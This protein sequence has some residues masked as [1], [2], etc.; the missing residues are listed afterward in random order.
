V[1]ALA[2]RS[3]LL[4]PDRPRLCVPRRPPSTAR[5]ARRASTTYGGGGKRGA[6]AGGEHCTVR[7]NSS[8]ARPSGCGAAGE[9][10]ADR[11][12]S[13]DA[14]NTIRCRWTATLLIYVRVSSSESSA[15]ARSAGCARL[16]G[17]GGAVS[18]PQRC[19]H[20]CDAP[21]E[22]TGPPPFLT[23]LGRPCRSSDRN[24]RGI[25]CSSRSVS[26]NVDEP[27]HVLDRRVRRDRP[28]RVAR[29]LVRP[30]STAAAQEPILE[31]LGMNDRA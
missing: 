21:S 24:V 4:G 26:R 19:G 6:A 20:A 22:R 16:A 30:Y 27:T 2:S 17:F 5:A 12:G 29:L 10:T 31:P 7:G 1:T 28:A 18:G 11:S 3:P 9:D 13:R 15:V 23:R 14:A 8:R 25:R